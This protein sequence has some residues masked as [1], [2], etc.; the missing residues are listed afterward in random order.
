MQNFQYLMEEL[1]TLHAR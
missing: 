1:L